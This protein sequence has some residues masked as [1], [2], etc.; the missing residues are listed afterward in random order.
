M[1]N[2]ALV[3][4]PLAALRSLAEG[5]LPAASRAASLAF[6]T[7][8]VSPDW[9][10]TWRRRAAQAATDPQSA[11]WITRAI[12]DLDLRLAVGRAGFHGPPAD[13]SVEVGYAVDPDFRRRGYARAAL[14]ALLER[15][16]EDPSVRCVRASV[17][18][19]NAASLA[20]IADYGFVEVGE[21]WDDEDGLERVFEV[22]ATPAGRSARRGA[23]L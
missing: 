19:D 14:E 20:L 23:W 18:P 2:I 22:S 8:F 11:S 5:D 13:G 9:R 21:R 15:A 12:V 16:E 10:S 17:R 1:P 3:Q 6:T 7:G 4:L